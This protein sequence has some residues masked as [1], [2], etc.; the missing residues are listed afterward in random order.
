MV[1]ALLI[2]LFNLFMAGPAEVTF[3]FCFDAEFLDLHFFSG[4][5]LFDILLPLVDDFLPLLPWLTF[6]FSALAVAGYVTDGELLW[7]SCEASV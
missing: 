1:F 2:L 4:A 6:F 7:L 3:D 5:P